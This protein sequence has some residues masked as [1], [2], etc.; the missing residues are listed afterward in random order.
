[1]APGG[2]LRI[3]AQNRAAHLKSLAGR[4]DHPSEVVHVRLRMINV[5]RFPLSGAARRLRDAIATAAS[6]DR[7]RVRVTRGGKVVAAIVSPEDLELLERLELE[8]DSKR[9][10]Q[11]RQD[12]GHGRGRPFD[13]VVAELGLDSH[14]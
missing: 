11:A 1:M 7:N 2:G 13:D 14:L 8:A 9:A 5:P 4:A 6:G 10:E 12:P 3:A